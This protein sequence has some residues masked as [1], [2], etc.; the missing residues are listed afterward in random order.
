MLFIVF[1]QKC[2]YL[3]SVNPIALLVTDN[4]PVAVTVRGNPQHRAAIA[5]FG[6]HRVDMLRT[7]VTIDIGSV[8]H[9]GQGCYVSPEFGKNFRHNFRKTSVGTIQHHFQPL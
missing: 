8:R 2:Y 1:S 3:I 5:D 9:T 4:Y 6:G 7:A